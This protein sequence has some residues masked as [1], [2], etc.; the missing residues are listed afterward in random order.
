MSRGLDRRPRVRKRNSSPWQL[1]AS[2]AAGMRRPSCVT[3]MARMPG[4]PTGSELGWG[5]AAIDDMYCS[6]GG[7]AQRN[8]CNKGAGEV[9]RPMLI[10]SWRGEDLVPSYMQRYLD[11]DRERVWIELLSMGEEVRNEPVYSDA[12]AVA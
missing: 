9:T 11:G 7:R 12:L 1:S 5:R 4:S 3:E 10:A 6:D 8:L 2:V